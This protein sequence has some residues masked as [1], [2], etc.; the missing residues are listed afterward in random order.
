MFWLLPW[1]QLVH[2]EDMAEEEGATVVVMEDM[3]VAEEDMGADMVDT[4]DMVATDMAKRRETPMLSQ[5]PTLLPKPMPI[6]VMEAME[7]DMADT[8]MVDTVD[9]ATDAKGDQLNQ[10]T[11]TVAMVDA[12]DTVDTEGTVD[13]DMVVTEATVDTEAMAVTEATV[14]MDMVDMDIMVKS[15]MS[16]IKKSDICDALKPKRRVLFC[17]MKMYDIFIF[18]PHQCISVINHKH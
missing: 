9:M 8:V 7:V 16:L 14:D 18:I 3:A 10:A 15:D 5:K 13:T 12:E 11:D 6:M 1:P 2:G 17:I 4:V